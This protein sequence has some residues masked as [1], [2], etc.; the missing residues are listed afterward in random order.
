MTSNSDISILPSLLSFPTIS[1]DREISQVL[2]NDRIHFNVDVF[3][4]EMSGRPPVFAQEQSAARNC[5]RYRLTETNDSTKTRRAGA[6]AIA[7]A[8]TVGTTGTAGQ[9]TA[10]AAGGGT[11][12]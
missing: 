1:N 11:G 9:A 6:A 12:C 10:A 5:R 4:F 3:G 8:A 7:S 2:P